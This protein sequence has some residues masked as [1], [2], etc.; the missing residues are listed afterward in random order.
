MFQTVTPFAIKYDLA[1]NSV[2]GEK[3]YVSVANNV[4]KKTGTVLMVWEHK[5]IPHIAGALG[6]DNPPAWKGEDFDSIWIVSFPAGKAT[7]A[8]DSEGISPSAEC[9]F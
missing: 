9:D 6:V 1:I 7:L 2:F 8:I 3:D 4:L 5:A